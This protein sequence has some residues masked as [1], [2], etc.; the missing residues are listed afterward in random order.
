MI[1]TTYYGIE[2]YHNNEHRRVGPPL[3]E[4]I[5]SKLFDGGGG[6]SV[7]DDGHTWLHVPDQDRVTCQ[8]GSQ[9]LVAIAYHLKRIRIDRFRYR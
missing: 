8:D 3:Y 2:S 6:P 4:H 5:F 7:T 1:V 9:D